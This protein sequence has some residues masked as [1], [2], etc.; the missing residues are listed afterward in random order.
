MVER[1]TSCRCVGLWVALCGIAWVAALPAAR[2]Q[3]D[4]PFRDESYRWR[5]VQIVGG[6]FITGIQFHPREPGLVYVRTDIG[7]SYRW[8]SQR[9]RWIPLNDFTSPENWNQLG[10]ESIGLDPT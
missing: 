9:S 3:S 4:A 6:G 1:W 7:G 2:A 5:N 8:D 10:V